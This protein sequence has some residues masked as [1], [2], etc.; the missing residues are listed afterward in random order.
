MKLDLMSEIQTG[1]PPAGAVK[2]AERPATSA[3]G[4]GRSVGK[5]QGST[6][7]AA[8]GVTVTLSPQSQNLSVQGPSSDT[9]DSGKVEA[10]KNAI[11][12]GSFQI[13]AEAIADKLLSNASEMLSASRR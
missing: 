2:P 9:F 12:N 11:A 1:A 3:T 13:N 6:A 4:N 8:S 7:P 5:S 10:I